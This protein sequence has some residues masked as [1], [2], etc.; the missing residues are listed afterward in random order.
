VEEACE[1]V[2]DGTHYTP[3]DVGRGVPFLTVKDMTDRSLDFV[4]CSFI[5]DKD[6]QA[7]K[8]GNC[9]PVN[10]DVLFSKD[11]TVGKVH[12]VSTNEP[13]AVLSSIAILRP[14]RDVDAGYLAHALRSPSV[15]AEA[16]RRKTG[17]AIRRIVLADLKRLRIPLPPLAEQ[18]RIANILDDADSLRS[19]RRTAL[20]G[21]H[22]LVKV[23]FL[24]MFGDPTSNPMRW[25]MAPFG[26][27]ATNEDAQRIPVK[28]FDRSH[29]P[30]VYPYYGASGIIDYVDRFLYSGNRLLI[31]EDGA[32]LIARSSP[33]AFIAHGQ[34]WVNNHAHVLADNGKADLV[35]L[36]NV[37]AHTDL[38]PYVTGSAQPKLTRSNLDRIPVPLPPRKL[39]ETFATATRHIAE[40]NDRQSAALT[41]LDALFASLQNRAFRGEL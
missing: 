8:A 3:A 35:Y 10:G 17:S 14:S 36:E 25:P 16:V 15:L 26:E 2:T 27:T 23:A 9:A 34:Y 28:A 6:F 19:K 31:G 5:A 29:M 1:L 24:E 30:K 33:I 12:V 32:N 18:R 40:L 38:K 37:L 41:Y 13:F 20:G 7:A 22:R 4:G 21:L 11:G 39:Q